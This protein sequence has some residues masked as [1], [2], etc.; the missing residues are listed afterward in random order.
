MTDFAEIIRVLADGGVEFIIVGGVAAAV[1][2]SARATYDVDV[3]YARTPGNMARLAEALAPLQPY[4][5]GAPAGLPFLWDAETLRRGLNF[6][7]TTTL[8]DID[9]LGEIVGG[10]GY[11]Q[12][13]SHSVTVSLFGRNCLCIDL[14]TLIHV[15]RAAGRPKDFEA[16]AELEALREEQRN[17]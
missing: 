6:T 15:K 17:D 14:E 1:H 2:G 7:L 11:D 16:I 10:G 4:L 8:G 5:R 9:V 12:L 13:R 3:V